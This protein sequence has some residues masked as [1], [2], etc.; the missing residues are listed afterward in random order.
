MPRL[1]PDFEKRARDLMALYPKAR[2]AL[3]P[4]CHL[5]QEQDG[6]LTEEA[7]EHIAELVDLTPAEVLSVASFYD[8]FHT[9]PVGTYLIGICTNIACLLNGGEELLHHAET[10]LGI[11]HGDTTPDGSFTLEEMECIAHC[12]KAPCLQVNYRYF[13][14][15]SNGELDSLCDDLKAGR[16]KDTIPPHGTLIRTKRDGGL[17]VS[18]EK[19]VAER[20]AMTAAQAA[21]AA[22]V[23]AAAA[24][25]KARG[26]AEAAQKAATGPTGDVEAKKDGG[27]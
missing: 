5:A 21:R 27:S 22:D 18:P 16:H 3:L 10:S 7:M 24:A 14:P 8:M 2:S 4:L 17:R 26:D 20:A 25:E 6:H 1:A 13:G 19:I 11:R 9:E 12:D 23:A 15:V